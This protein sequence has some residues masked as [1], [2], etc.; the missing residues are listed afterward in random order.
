MSLA[1]RRNIKYDSIW[2]IVE[3]KSLKEF[4]HKARKKFF[5][6]TMNNIIPTRCS[7]F[8]YKKS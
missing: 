3:K 2:F 6:I 4:W 8:V 5:K 1:K 7:F